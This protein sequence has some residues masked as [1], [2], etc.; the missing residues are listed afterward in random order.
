[1][2]CQLSGAGHSPRWMQ[3]RCAQRGIRQAVGRGNAGG[4][5]E[6]EAGLL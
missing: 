4:T 6:P 2:F 3:R 5:S 1:M